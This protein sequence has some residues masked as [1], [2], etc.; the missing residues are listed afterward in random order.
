MKL[1]LLVFAFLLSCPLFAQQKKVCFSI[2]DLPVVS[3]GDKS[4]E[5][6]L[7]VTRRLVKSLQELN[8]PAI[9]FVNEFKLYDK[10]G[11]NIKPYQKECLEIWL[12]AG[13]DLGNHTY[14]HKDINSTPLTIYTEEIIKG[15]KVT[16]ELLA[17]YGKEMKYFR[18]P[19]LHVGE[20]KSLADSLDQFLTSHGYEV[21][22]VT[23]DNA[24]YLFAVAYH[25]SVQKGDTEMAH[26]IG[27]DYIDY[28]EEKVLFYEQQSQKLFGRQ[29][30]QTLLIH[31]SLLNA[32]YMA[33]LGH[34]FIK[35]GYE[36][37]SAE[38][39]LKDPSYQ[40]PVTKFGRYGI[41]W[42]DRW[43]LSVDKSDDFFKGEPDTPDYIKNFKRD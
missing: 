18:H 23:I 2:D 28:M 38:E 15:E 12:E 8:N 14:K 9:G 13:L 42:I 37:V 11:K 30:P 7:D 5:F 26:R 36:F 25:Y 41:S 34:V 6:H 22:P 33:K 31:A 10:A 35:H 17:H 43:A 39:V 40:T 19:Y 24:D 32:D 16:K 1:N 4:P 29:I 27:E 20:R 3:Y 21:L